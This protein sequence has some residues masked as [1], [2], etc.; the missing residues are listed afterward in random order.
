MLYS[1]YHLFVAPTGAPLNVNV[2]DT[3]STALHVTWNPPSKAETHGLI[4]EYNI[5]YRQGECTVAGKNQT[6]GT[7]LTNGTNVMPWSIVTVNGS[8]TSVELNNLTKWSCYEVRVRAVTIKSGVWSETKQR[9]TREDGEKVYFLHL[10][11][12]KNE[13]VFP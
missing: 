1:I 13:T 4:R 3:S 5:Q 9:R 2:T 10:N 8:L 7:N 11:L 6:N 12:L